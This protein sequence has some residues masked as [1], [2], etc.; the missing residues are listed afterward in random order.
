M[1]DVQLCL[2]R[3]GSGRGGEQVEERG[4]VCG[5]STRQTGVSDVLSQGGGE[6]QEVLLEAAHNQ[7][8]SVSLQR[9]CLAIAEVAP[10]ADCELFS[11][12]TDLLLASR[13]RNC[14]L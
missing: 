8:S 2:R 13:V 5:G 3:D 6:I 14:H 11:S 9:L 7:P 1:K 4:R 12:D 10:G